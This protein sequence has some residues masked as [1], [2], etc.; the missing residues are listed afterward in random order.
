MTVPPPRLDQRGQAAVLESLTA[1]LVHSLHGDWSLLT[2]DVRANRPASTRSGWHRSST[3]SS[4][5]SR[6][7][8]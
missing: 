6:T 3:G 1:L 8:W 7:R 5:R 2:L 4:S